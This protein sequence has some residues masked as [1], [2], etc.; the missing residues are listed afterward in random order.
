MAPYSFQPSSP[1]RHRWWTP[2]DDLYP[3]VLGFA[4]ALWRWYAKVV[5]T[6]PS[7]HHGAG[8][9]AVLG[10][11]RDYSTS[12]PHGQPL[13]VTIGA[14]GIGVTGD[15]DG[16]WGSCPIRTGRRLDDLARARTQGRAVPIEEDEVRG[17]WWRCGWL[18]RRLGGWRRRLCG[19]RCGR[20]QQGKHEQAFH[21]FH[22]QFRVSFRHNIYIF[23][24]F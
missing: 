18:W 23:E 14:R 22:R 2:L 5:F 20:Q 12:S 15:L 10:E 11:R 24:D 3:P 13:V 4:H 16:D 7:H 6:A 17:R 8:R 19:A 9:H 1:H 21:P